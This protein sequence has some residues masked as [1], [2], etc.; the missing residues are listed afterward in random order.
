ML[1]ATA[2]VLGDIIHASLVVEAGALLEG[3]CRRLEVE[4]VP[5]MAPVTVASEDT[6]AY[7]TAP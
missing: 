7:S 1:G 3:H 4:T 2:R 6:P 5:I